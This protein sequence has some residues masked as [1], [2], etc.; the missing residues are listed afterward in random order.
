[1]S[2]YLYA[3]IFL[4]AMSI[5]F[6]VIRTPDVSKIQYLDKIEWECVACYD[7]WDCPHVSFDILYCTAV[8]YLNP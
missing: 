1:M 4:Y 6:D 3:P 7:L 2:D 8:M 5:D